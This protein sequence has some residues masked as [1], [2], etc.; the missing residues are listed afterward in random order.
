MHYK[1]L[2]CVETGVNGILVVH[3]VIR[4]MAG[5]TGPGCYFRFFIQNKSVMPACT[6]NKTFAATYNGL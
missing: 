1:T 4:Q 5:H 6:N 3:A 2:E